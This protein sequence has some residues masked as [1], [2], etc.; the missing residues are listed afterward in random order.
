MF[1]K[2]L[3]SLAFLSFF[4][5]PA[6]AQEDLPDPGILP[7]SPFYFAKAFFEDVGTFFVFGDLAKAERYQELAQKRIA[8]A[9]AMAEKEPSEETMERLMNRY[10][11]QLEKS[12][13]KVEAVKERNQENERERVNQITEK[14]AR[15]TAKH[16]SV[17]EAMTEEVS[18]EIKTE[19]LLAKE[20]SSDGQIKALKLL[21]KENTEEAVEI[22]SEAIEVRLNKIETDTDYEDEEESEEAVKEYKKYSNLGQEISELAKGL[23]IDS[24]TV[25][26]LVEKAT[27]HHLEALERVQ[28]QVKVNEKAQEK[29]KEAIQVRTRV[30]TETQTRTE[31]NGEA[32]VGDCD[33][34]DKNDKDDGEEE[35][36]KERTRNSEESGK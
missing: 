31:T 19:I 24:S 21:V 33:D 35:T 14:I 30:R 4:A 8:E 6:L 22:F 29:L 10:Q 11:N 16:F 26:E 13:E 25:E 32:C 9:K 27:S 5:P 34:E 12:L 17:L 7:G 28:A 1:K 18:D 2:I 23:R 36:G 15:N 20:A 3:F